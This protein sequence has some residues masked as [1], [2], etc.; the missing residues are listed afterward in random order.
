MK[1]H[2]IFLDID[3]VLCTMRSAIAFRFH[4]KKTKVE[5]P[6]F[7]PVAI[8]LLN[9]TLDEIKEKNIPVLFVVSSAW[10]IHDGSTESLP[11]VTDQLR[12]YGFKGEFHS[13]WRTSSKRG[14]RGFELIDW[15]DRHEG[16]YENFWTLEDEPQDIVCH[17]RLKGHVVQPDCWTGID[18]KD[19]DKL[20]DLI[21]GEYSDEKVYQK[22]TRDRWTGIKL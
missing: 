20:E 22:R 12:E 6:G 4:E 10:R 14:G 3:G 15:L 1:P 7:D 18:Y 8:E 21:N 11:L 5:H 2:I 19:M 16:E 17:N 9:Q 13:D